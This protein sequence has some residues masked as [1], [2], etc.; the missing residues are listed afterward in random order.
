MPD[1]IVVGAGTGGT[2]ATIGRYLRYRR[3]PTRL[4]V[5]DP[6]G[7]AF[8]PGWRDGDPAAATGRASRIEGIGRPRVEPLVRADDRRP[9]DLRPRRRLAG[10][11]ARSSSGCTG[12]RAGGSTGTNLWGA[13][14]A[15]RR[16][17]RRRAHRQRR[18]PA[19][20]RRRAVRPHLLRRRL[21]GRPGPGPG[22]ARGRRCGEFAATGE[23][24]SGGAPPGEPCVTGRP[25]AR[26]PL[27]AGN[28]QDR[29][30]RADGPRPEPFSE[31]GLAM[32]IVVL[33]KQ[34]PDSGTRA[35]PGPGGQH[36]RPGRRR[37]RHQRDRRVRHR[38]G[39]DRQGGPGR[40]GHRADRRPRV[41]HRRDPQGAL[42]GRRQGRARRRRRH[43]RLVRGADQRRPR[44][45]A[46][47]AGLRPGPLRRR[48]PPTARSR[49]C[50][51][52][53]PSGWASRSCPAPA[54]SPSRAHGEG[55]AADRRRLLGPRGAAAGDR[56]HLGHHQR[57]AL[58]LLQGD[59]GGEEEARGEE[60]ARRPRRRRLH[61]RPGQRHQPGA[62]LR[63]PP[64]EGR[65]RQGHRRGRRRREARRLPR[66]ARRSSEPADE[67]EETLP[68]QR[69]W[70]WPSSTRPATASARPPWSR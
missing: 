3:L 58:P 52:C 15:H 25:G 65:G 24:R 4:A 18:H 50:P 61:R 42:D 35:Q 63:R 66:R 19:V 39:A 70:S 56:V 10:R 45:R 26:P 6:E 17:A 13:F 49:S 43:P 51:P 36:R 16:D 37:Q 64:A 29:S 12:R 27:P 55:R 44:R 68:W 60:V 33:V 34:V 22:A 59:H 46:A 38:G 31:V 2:S 14:T 32:N 21:G 53:S 11:D 57:A 5:V 47:A 62:R 41:G 8:Y 7:S 28:L 48:A 67:E 69:S 30:R 9:D 23:W 40:R 20:R 54:S 1:W